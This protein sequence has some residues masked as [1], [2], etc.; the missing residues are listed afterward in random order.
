MAVVG[1]GKLEDFAHDRTQD[2]LRFIGGASENVVQ[3]CFHQSR[4]AGRPA[5]AHPGRWAQA[6]LTL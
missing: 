6:P 1:R 4:E 2:Y 3:G 5:C